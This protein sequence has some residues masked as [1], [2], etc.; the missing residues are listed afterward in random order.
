MHNEQG[1]GDCRR[2]H[3]FDTTLRDGQQC[4]GAGMNFKK[5]LEYA[6][7]A[8]GIGLDVLEAGFPAASKLDFEIVHAIAERYATADSAPTV[9]ALCQLRDEQID[10]TIEALGPCVGR[11]RARLHTYFP[12]D[13]ELMNA[14]LGERARN[15]A[16]F[17][18]NTH[19][20]IRRAVAA[21]CE[22]EF[23]PE[24][25]S[26]MRE[27]FDFTTDLLCAAVEA[28]ARVLNCPDTIGGSCV[29]EGDEYYVEKMKRHAGIIAQKYPGRPVIW[30]AHCHNDFGLAV[31]NSL[32]GVFHGPARQIEGCFTGIGERAG[33]AS[34][35]QMVM[36][37]KHFGR[38]HSPDAPFYTNMRTEKLQEICDFVS[39]NM[40]PR[41]PHFPI[42][43]DNAS[44][45]SSGGHTNAVL[46]NPLAYQPFDPKEVGKEISLMFG[47]LSGS[48]HAQSI[49]HQ[50]KFRCDES[51]K[52]EITQYL[53]DLYKE[54]R[55]GI[56]D[57]ELLKGYFIFRSPIKVESFDYSRSAN[58]S[59]V[60][61]RGQ[62]FGQTGDITETHEGRDSALAA[63]KKAIDREF[64]GWHIQIHK[65]MSDREGIDANSVSTIVIVDDRNR[66]F[67][68]K[69]EDQDIEIS[70]MKALIAAVNNAYVTLNFQGD[71]PTGHGQKHH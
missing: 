57:E 51:E 63:L 16:Q 61:I 49:I 29:L 67:E 52:A 18:Q 4:P 53:K 32:N 15:K 48:N 45:H 71:A 33:N 13:P 55:K 62:F 69:G 21:G 54:R 46:K 70:A 38:Q 5:N 35:E 60:H 34:I 44:K 17:V 2:I 30:S 66:T 19:D 27:N 20:F 6:E 25:Y 50:F 65:S 24:G 12:V 10:R 56:T 23:S 9:A 7:L 68:G 1:V 43:G 47:P 58:R 39:S 14:S 22:V 36:I 59:S 42:A 41:Q 8:L 11:G 3:V 28:G 37:I 31:I 64:P 26:R 40:L